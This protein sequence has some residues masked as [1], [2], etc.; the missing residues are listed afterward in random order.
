MLTLNVR[1]R[2]GFRPCLRQIRRT[3]FSLSPVTAAMVRVLQWVEFAG[4]TGAMG[5]HRSR[6]A[7]ILQD[8]PFELSKLLLDSSEHSLQS[9]RVR[10]V[11]A[12]VSPK[13]DRGLI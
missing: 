8:L 7:R 2:C 5:R 3:L 12:Q 4:R 9:L 11:H 10:Q 6:L 13:K 1:V